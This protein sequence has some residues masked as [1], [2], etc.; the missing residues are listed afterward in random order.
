MEITLLTDFF[1]H[2]TKKPRDKFK[3]NSYSK[4]KRILN[5]LLAIFLL[6]YGGYGIHSGELYIPIP[7]GNDVTLLGDLIY[8]AFASFILGV[9]YLLTEIVDHYDKRDNENIYLRIKAGCQVFGLLIFI[10][11]IIMGNITLAT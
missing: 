5:L 8:M 11:A 1:E 2:L 7:R 9:I 4:S 3:P 10:F 6:S